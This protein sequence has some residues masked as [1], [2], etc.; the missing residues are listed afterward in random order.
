MAGDVVS[1]SLDPWLLSIGGGIVTTLLAVI[2]KLWTER[3]TERRE[4]R[5]E[6]AQLRAE[7]ATANERILELSREAQ[8]RTDGHTRDHL[9]DLRRLAGLPSSSGPWPAV[10]SP[11]Q[12][13]VVIRESPIAPAPAPAEPAGVVRKDARPPRA[14]RKPRD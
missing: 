10:I 3:A 2:G 7:L 11:A 12:R 13:D 5:D 14:A 1:G 4:H 9:R 6:V 8:E